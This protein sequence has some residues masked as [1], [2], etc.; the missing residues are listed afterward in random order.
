[1]DRLDEVYDRFSY[2]EP[3]RDALAQLAG[4]FE[5]LNTGIR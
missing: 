2:L 4:H 3:K 1:V 5:R